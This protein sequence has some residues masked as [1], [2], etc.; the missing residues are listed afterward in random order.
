MCL[1][2]LQHSE[3]CIGCELSVRTRNVFLSFSPQ[4]V[5]VH[6]PIL[7]GPPYCAECDSVTHA[8]VEKGESTVMPRDKS[9]LMYQG[10]VCYHTA[11]RLS[12]IAIST[13]RLSRVR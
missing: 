5:R 8:N 12:Q 3:L 6:I 10:Y 4:V 7:G 11:N 1:L 9:E 13:H 2:T